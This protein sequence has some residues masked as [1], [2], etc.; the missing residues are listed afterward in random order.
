MWAVG[1]CERCGTVV[2]FRTT[3]PVVKSLMRG[4]SYYCPVCGMYKLLKIHAIPNAQQLDK[5]Y[6]ELRVGIILESNAEVSQYNAQE[7]S[8][9][10]LVKKYKDPNSLWWLDEDPKDTEGD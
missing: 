6:N 2:A 7:E 9:E 8:T 3:T 10:G 5:A 4:H 1:I